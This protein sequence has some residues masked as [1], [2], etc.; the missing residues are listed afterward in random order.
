MYSPVLLDHLQHPRHKGDL[1]SPTS[2]GEARYAPCGDRLR[3]TFLIEQDRLVNAGFTAYGCAAVK[4][5]G[6]AVAELV[7]DMSVEE[8]RSLTA[9][10]LDR[11]LGGLPPSKRHALLMVLECLHQAL[12][13]RQTLNPKETRMNPQ[14]PASTHRKENQPAR[15][16]SFFVCP[17]GH[18]S[19]VSRR[20]DSVPSQAAPSPGG[21]PQ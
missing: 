17:A 8:A 5:A 19:P 9:F 1:A 11:L 20:P 14:E 12:G 10:D 3:L 13:P 2:T 4:A 21:E 15:R 7:A 6:S 16:A 18:S